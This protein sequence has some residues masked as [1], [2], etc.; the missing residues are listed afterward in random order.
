MH[1]AI[2]ARAVEE[3]HLAVGR[4]KMEE[5]VG[6]VRARTLCIGASGDP[7]AFPELEPL[8]IRL[9]DATT[10]VIEGGT[11]GLLEHKSV[12]VAEAVVAFLTTDRIGA[13]SD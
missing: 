12:E 9:A 1:D 4:Y 7:F 3:G 10:T 13:L 6:L 8:S 2:A 5:T 11:V